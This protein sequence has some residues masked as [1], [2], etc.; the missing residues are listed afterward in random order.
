MVLA[1]EVLFGFVIETRPD[2]HEIEREVTCHFHP[3]TPSSVYFRLTP[4]VYVA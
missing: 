4:P 2:A 3:T 1:S